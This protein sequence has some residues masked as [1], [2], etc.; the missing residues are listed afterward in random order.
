ME[1][2]NSRNMRQI[3]VDIKTENWKLLYKLLY[4]HIKLLYLK[5]TTLRFEFYLFVC[6]CVRHS[7]QLAS[8]SLDFP[9]VSFPPAKC[10]YAQQKS[11]CPLSSQ[12]VKSQNN[13]K[14]NYCFFGFF[15]PFQICCCCCEIERSKVDNATTGKWTNRAECWKRSCKKF[16]CS[17]V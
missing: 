5:G 16:T 17:R 8:H 9:R 1:C 10:K 3:N 15:P 12:L 14:I 6:E 2:N 11:I 7:S 4:V 13:R